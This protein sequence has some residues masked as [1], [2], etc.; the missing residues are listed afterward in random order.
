MDPRC[1]V[2]LQMPCTQNPSTSAQAQYLSLPTLQVDCLPLP[3]SV[4][5]V[6]CLV[7]KIAEVHG[8]SGLRHSSFSHSFLRSCLGPGTCPGAQQGHARVPASPLFRPVVCITSLP[9]LSVF[10]QKICSKYVDLLNI[11]VSQWKRHFLTVSSQPS[12]AES[13]YIVF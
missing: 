9:T 2:L 11:L 6:G 12:C 5:I 13:L 4:G 7:A 10:S 8:D 3:M 1:Y